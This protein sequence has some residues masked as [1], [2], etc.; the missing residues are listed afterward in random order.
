MIDSHRQI[1][2]LVAIGPLSFN[3][4]VGPKNVFENVRVKYG[5]NRVPIIKKFSYY[6][7]IFYFR[8]H[9]SYINITWSTELNSETIGH[10]LACI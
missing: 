4:Y 6:T 8:P 2:R 1:G 3:I 5:N 7:V 9:I 10:I